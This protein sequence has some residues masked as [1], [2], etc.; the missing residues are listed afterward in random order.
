MLTLTRRTEYALIAACHLARAGDRV[1]SARDL[2]ARYD[3]RPALLMNVL[4]TLNRRG[5]VNSVRGVHGGYTLAVP[6]EKLTLARL[7][8]AVEGSARLMRC[9][10]VQEPLT[11]ESGCELE[12][13]CPIRLPMRRVQEYFGRFLSSVSI[14]DLAFDKGYDAREV[15]GQTHL[16]V[17]LE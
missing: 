17:T 14:A 9:A 5:I 8:R 15:G 7:I 13:T 16:R 2:A 12:G 3:I 6:P 1:V 10:P 11:D 4:K